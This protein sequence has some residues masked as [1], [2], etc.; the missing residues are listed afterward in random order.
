MRMRIATAAVA[1][2]GLVAI[3][4]VAAAAPAYA[5]QG[6][7]NFRSTVTAISP[8]AAGVEA[9]V[10]NLDDRLVLTSNGGHTVEIEGYEGEPYARILPDGTV[11]LN[12]LSPAYYLN[13][14]RFAEADVP[15]TAD[16]EAPPRWETV[17]SSGRLEFHDHRIH[18]MAQGTPPQ[19]TDEGERTKVF[20]WTVPIA[21]D[22]EPASVEGEL[23]WVPDDSGFPVAAIVGLA[24]FAL[25]SIALVVFVRR[26]RS[27]SGADGDGGKEAW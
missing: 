20:D 17:S 25:A 6:D 21:V 9:E 23:F 3:Q 1:L 14:D 12:T 11:Q 19:V 24:A 2:S 15:E 7:P 16:A 5:H 27:R 13:E 26:R 22:G 10:A 18:W 4:A 8:P